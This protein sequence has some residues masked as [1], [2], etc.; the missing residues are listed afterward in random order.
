VSHTE[1]LPV[2]LK[3]LRLP[4]VQ[5][6]Y[7][8][9]ARQAQSDEWSYQRYLKELVELET[10]ERTERRIQRLLKRSELPEGKTLA[11][12]EQ[13][14]LPMK[15][16]RQL[17]VLCEGG[18]LERTE[19][20][21]AFGLPGRGKSH[22]AAAIA[23]ELII[24][25]GCPAYFTS[26]HRLVERLLAAKQRLE[27]EKELK[28]LD[29]FDVVVLDDIGYVQQSRE[30]MEVLFTFLS[31]RYERRS[32][33]ITSNLVFSEWS[34]IF[35]DPMTTAAAIDRLVHH[36]VILELNTES[37][38]ARVAKNRRKGKSSSKQTGDDHEL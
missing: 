25:R 26:T 13:K 38:R 4:S 17:P 10:S 3:A 1:S 22:V 31:Q 8:R 11:T 35:K 16:R 30:E 6:H 36:S 9:V 23:R 32:L 34:K 29:R 18:F 24:T 37:Y 2:M 28:K 20:I 5:H 15:V 12:L 19:N 21:L 33:I 7:Q 14:Y 27:L